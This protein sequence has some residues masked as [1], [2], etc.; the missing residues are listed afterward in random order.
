MSTKS[1]EKSLSTKNAWKHGNSTSKRSQRQKATRKL[2]QITTVQYNA[3]HHCLWFLNIRKSGGYVP[4][5]GFITLIVKK[6]KFIACNLV[7]RL[8]QRTG[9]RFSSRKSWRQQG[10]ERGTYLFNEKFPLTWEVDYGIF[11]WVFVKKIYANKSQT[12]LQLKGEI[13]MDI[14]SIAPNVCERESRTSK[15]PVFISKI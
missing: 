8:I 6:S 1:E 14:N 2:Q 11:S 15:N 13:Q 3:K 9:I 7:K 12:I 4:E 5:N 10:I